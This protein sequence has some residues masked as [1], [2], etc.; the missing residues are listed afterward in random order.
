MSSPEVTILLLAERKPIQ[1][2]TPE[3]ALDHDTSSRSISKQARDLVTSLVQAL[4]RIA[5]PVSEQQHVP[6]AHQLD[7][8]QQLG[9]VRHAVHQNPDI[10]ARRP[11]Q[12]VAPPVI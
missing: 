6:G 1:M 7:T 12:T 10:V 8:S 2:R 3:E 11:R 9:E 4:I 5:P